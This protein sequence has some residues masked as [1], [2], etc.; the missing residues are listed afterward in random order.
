MKIQLPANT[1]SEVE[2]STSYT[3]ANKG[4]NMKWRWPPP[5]PINV[6]FIDEDGEVLQLQTEPGDNGDYGIF[7]RY[8]RQQGTPYLL[9]GIM[10][11]FTYNGKLINSSVRETGVVA[12]DDIKV[13][14]TTKVPN[15]TDFH[16]WIVN[17]IPAFVNNQPHCF[18]NQVISIK[19]DQDLYVVKEYSEDSDSFILGIR[20]TGEGAL[21]YDRD[22]FII[23]L[24]DYYSNLNGFGHDF[25]VYLQGLVSKHQSQVEM[26]ATN[27]DL[28]KPNQTL[29]RIIKIERQIY[30]L[31]NY[32]DD[33][34][35]QEL[36]GEDEMK[37]FSHYTEKLG[38]ALTSLINVKR[39]FSDTSIHKV[40]K[41]ILQPR[42]LVYV[43]RHNEDKD[44]GPTWE[45]RTI[46]SIKEHE[47]IDG[48]GP[49]RTYAIRWVKSSS[50]VYYPIFENG[51]D[52]VVEDYQVMSIDD[53]ETPKHIK[54]SDW[55]GV[56][57]VSDKESNDP[58]AR[59]VGWYT[60]NIKGVEESF[61]HL[62]DALRAYDIS[63]AQTKR[64][65]L[66]V[67]DLNLPRDWVQFFKSAI[68]NGHVGDRMKVLNV[69][70]CLI[71]T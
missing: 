56:K 22:Q 59:E 37:L 60:V 47:D 19:G 39:H 31:L 24:R 30:R 1:S 34:K 67:N 58:W 3:V 21:R 27:Q 11:D 32:I 6:N 52:L 8:A 53:Y 9:S 13:Y 46:K 68:Q 51:K 2:E 29:L 20:R 36:C 64:G 69:E 62:S 4:L 48:Y 38:K 50:D 18:I 12:G 33:V 26:L 57:H 28:D 40:N 7:D 49:R 44:V 41:P 43:L 35:D 70:L 5:P 42:D 25:F 14:V 16:N 55:K 63:Q 10:Y 17:N 15:R 71:H 45:K 54:E 65:D 61:I 23:L 66:K